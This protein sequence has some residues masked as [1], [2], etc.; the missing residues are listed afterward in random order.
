LS[1]I[2]LDDIPMMILLPLSG[3]ALDGK[4]SFCRED[5]NQ[6]NSRDSCVNTVKPSSEL[7][8]VIQELLDRDLIAKYDRILS[9]HRDVQEAM[10]YHDKE[11][12]QS[13]FD[14]ASRLI[15]EHFPKREKDETLYSQWGR[16][17]ELIDHVVSLSKGYSKHA[18][19]LN[20]TVEFV[21]V[22]SNAAW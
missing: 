15:F 12:L 16:C 3:A 13:C 18:G 4:L 14:T 21:M 7:E 6:P 10:N 2:A 19:H 5:V 22:L 8:R 1:D 17:A 11:D 9:I 20:G